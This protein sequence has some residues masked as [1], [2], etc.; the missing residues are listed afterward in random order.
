MK[1]KG[2]TLVVEG[3]EFQLVEDGFNTESR[4]VTVL[5]RSD[6]KQFPGKDTVH[7]SDLGGWHGVARW[8]ADA[9]LHVPNDGYR[10]HEPL[11]R[12]VVE[13]YQEQHPFQIGEPRAY[14]SQDGRHYV[15]HVENAVVS[16]DN[17]SSLS[18]EVDLYRVGVL[19]V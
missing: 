15:A 10:E 13:T 6:S 9:T 17:Q 18:G 11:L 8:T 19:G 12:K 5:A 14:A 2:L 4:T 16:G 7:W 1:R 3:Q